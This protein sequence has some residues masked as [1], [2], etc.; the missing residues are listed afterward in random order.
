MNLLT[1]LFKG[2]RRNPLGVLDDMI[3]KSETLARQLQPLANRLLT[4]HSDGITEITAFFDAVSSFQDAADIDPLIA[5]IAEHNRNGHYNEL[6][7]KLI[8]LRTHVINA[9]RDIYGYNRTRRG[10]HVTDN[11]VH[12]GNVDGYWTKTV[13][14]IKTKRQEEPEYYARMNRQAMQ[15][16]TSHSTPIFKCLGAIVQIARN[17]AA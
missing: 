6:L 16:M 1:V 4:R 7:E 12:L 9:G 15:F 3:A 14:Y 13:A 11:D 2:K 5:K 10:Q 8:L 17:E